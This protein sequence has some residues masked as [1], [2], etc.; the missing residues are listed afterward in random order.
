MSRYNRLTAALPCHGPPAN[1]TGATHRTSRSTSLAVK[2]LCALTQSPTQG[3]DSVGWDC[4][5]AVGTCRMLVEEKSH[6]E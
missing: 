1:G 5:A 2:A 3:A 4:S 6:S